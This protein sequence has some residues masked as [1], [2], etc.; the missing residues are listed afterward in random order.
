MNRMLPFLFILFIL[1]GTSFSEIQVKGSWNVEFARFTDRSDNIKQRSLGL[2]IGKS[3]VTFLGQ[4]DYFKIYEEANPPAS[5]EDEIS[6]SYN[7][8]RD[9][10]IT[11]SYAVQGDKIYIYVKVYDVVTRRLKFESGYTGS[12][13][14]DIFDSIDKI[15]QNLK[16]D[17]L[18]SV[19]P[20]DEETIIRYRKRTKIIREEVK[21]DRSIVTSI[22]WS[23]AFNARPYTGVPF[24]S[25]DGRFDWLNV[26]GETFMPIIAPAFD[27]EGYWRNDLMDL[28]AGYRFENMTFGA[29]Y[30]LTY[31]FVAD[32]P[33]NNAQDGTGP[34]VY[35]RYD[36]G[37]TFA[38]KAL[39]AITSIHA[40]SNADSLVGSFPYT[41]P[42]GYIAG[43][44]GDYYFMENFGIKIEYYYAWA[45]DQ[46]TGLFFDNTLVLIGFNYRLDFK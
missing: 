28:Y 36:F 8:G 34:L 43:I 30:L 13:G 25:L 26:G 12:S 33:S 7:A 20:M 41:Q 24:I 9:M 46:S 17:L 18:K 14:E 10:L 31:R 6:G 3:L 21:L 32:P 15:I 42:L 40:T 22:G 1:A 38:L 37:N 29:G 16:L 27:S 11:G 19:K 2:V 39:F 35:F 45:S 23:S 44:E 4:V 5:L